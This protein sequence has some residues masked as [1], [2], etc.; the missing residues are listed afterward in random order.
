MVEDL[1]RLFAGLEPFVAR[2]RHIS[3][4]AV[5]V[6]LLLTQQQGQSITEIA[7]KLHEPPSAASLRIRELRKWPGKAKGEGVAYLKEDVMDSRVRRVY[8]TESG[9]LLAAE[10]RRALSLKAGVERT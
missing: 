4:K 10:V 7:A 8:L 6:F 9:K 2:K 3:A 1:S 5:A